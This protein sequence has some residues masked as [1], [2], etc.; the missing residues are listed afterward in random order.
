MPLTPA[1]GINRKSFHSLKLP[2]AIKGSNSVS[3]SQ[4]K[5]SVKAEIN[6]K[7]SCRNHI[8]KEIE[9]FYNIAKYSI[10]K[11]S[12]YSK[13]IGIEGEGGIGKSR[14]VYEFRKN[15]IQ[16]N[17]EQFLVTGYSDVDSFI[18]KKDLPQ[19]KE[20]LEEKILNAN[21]TK[22]PLIV[23]VEDV[24]WF[25]VKERTKLEKFIFDYSGELPSPILSSVIFILTYR[26]SSSV[27]KLKNLDAFHEINLELFTED[28]SKI[29]IRNSNLRKGK[30]LNAE[31]EQ[32]IIKLSTGNPF[33]IEEYLKEMLGKNIAA[34]VPGTIKALI[35]YKLSLISKA[36]LQILEIISLWDGEIKFDVLEKICSKLNILIPTENELQNNKL[37]RAVCERG[38]LRLNLI[39]DIYKEVIYSSINENVKIIFHK[40]V[41]AILESEGSDEYLTKLI[42]HLKNADEPVKANHYLEKYIFKNIEE[43]EYELA[44]ERIDELISFYSDD[45]YKRLEITLEKIRCLRLLV[46]KGD[47][48]IELKKIE[49]VIK[50]YK[51]TELYLRYL[52]QLEEYYFLSNDFTTAFRLI[53]KGLKLSREQKSIIME[54]EFQFLLTRNLNTTGNV[55]KC[56]K[57]ARQLLTLNNSLGDKKFYYWAQYY[58][59]VNLQVLQHYEE[60]NKIIE[61]C[62]AETKADLNIEYLNKFNKV[63]SKYYFLIQDFEKFLDIAKQQYR[64]EISL[65]EIH[66]TLQTLLNIVDCLIRLRN[67]KEAKDILNL[68]LKFAVKNNSSLFK[69]RAN[70]GL[71]NLYLAD[72]NFQSA[73]RIGKNLL[74]IY[75]KS[76]YRSLVL[77]YSNLLE[78]YFN[79]GN[80]ELFTE[81]Y[82]KAILYANKN[83][84]ENKL[85]VIHHNFGYAYYL[86]GNLKLAEKYIKKSYNIIK[87]KLAYSQF[88]EVVLTYAEVLLA[89]GKTG[90]S[91][92]MLEHIAPYF[93]NR[94]FDTEKLFFDMFYKLLA[95]SKRED[96]IQE[97]LESSSLIDLFLNKSI[98]VLFKLKLFYYIIL[99]SN[100]STTCMSLEKFYKKLKFT[101]FNLETNDKTILFYLKLI[102]K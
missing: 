82:K 63:K 32:K 34:R 10:S 99:I 18:F 23:I 88:S 77:L 30:R 56:L 80:I 58:I 59:A 3:A 98:D 57:Q 40:S 94:K 41:A 101:S 67:R 71:M 43:R 4:L 81:C 72:N 8:L 68:I 35:S 69:K 78:V 48:E 19:I 79:I 26:N 84:S 17:S 65:H 60:S 83:K 95:T 37:L 100:T 55:N 49:K 36:E 16:K 15:L 46:R 73:L 97:F 91:L 87:K 86:S 75:D 52:Y 6:T 7:F 61:N 76:D 47:M 38:E 70:E 33:Y 93:K 2:R 13:V 96:K 22:L 29:F 53:N 31:L 66:Q 74:N 21:S 102:K 44:L 9:S 25:D 5:K 11:G 89:I 45:E 27:S 20:F 50:K 54:A 24:H 12:S 14:L 90:L 28:E 62:M 1:A 42:H 92:D 51:S 64:L 85:A 39:H